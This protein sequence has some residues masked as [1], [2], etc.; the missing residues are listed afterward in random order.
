MNK[1]KRILDKT[2][3]FMRDNGVSFI[4]IFHKG[5]EGIVSIGGDTKILHDALFNILGEYKRG[6][7]NDGQE[8]VADIILDCISL[9]Y[10]PQ[11]IRQEMAK[12]VDKLIPKN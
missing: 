8:A 3:Q 10:S 2:L 6:N 1:F 4:C 7:A 5:T 9:V 12:R 11:Q